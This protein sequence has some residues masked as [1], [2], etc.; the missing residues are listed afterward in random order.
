MPCHVKFMPG[1]LKGM[2]FISAKKTCD[3]K[4]NTRSYALT[5]G[6]LGVKVHEVRVTL[7]VLNVIVHFAVTCCTTRGTRQSPCQAHGY[8]HTHARTHARTHSKDEGLAPAY[9]VRHYILLNNSPSLGRQAAWADMQPGPTCSL[10]RQAAWA[11]MQPGPTCSLARQAAWPD[12][13]PG[14]TCS[15]ARQAAWADMQPGPTCSLD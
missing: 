9:L 13:Q 8:K 14:P 3:K 1:Q 5:L 4:Q 12:R 6:G 11:D 15:L 7:N 10:G 2:H